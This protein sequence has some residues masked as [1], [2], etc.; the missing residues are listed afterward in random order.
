MY[1]I[2]ALTGTGEWA[3]YGSNIFFGCKNNCKY[4]YA[5][6]SAL[7]FKKISNS[8]E[9]EQMTLNKN[10]ANAI[11]RKLDRPFMFPT[12]H[13]ILSEHIGVVTDYLTR[14]LSVGNKVLIVTKP[15]L[16]CVKVLC[17]ELES[18]KSQ[19]LFRFTIG[20]LDERIST[21]WEP[22][23][24]LPS[25]RTQSLRYTFEKGFATSISAEP[26]L[27]SVEKARDMFYCLESL[28]TDT[29][30]FGKMNKISKRV[31]VSPQDM[32]Y[33]ELIKAQQTD[34]NIRKLYYMLKLEP[35]VMWKDSI[36]AVL[37]I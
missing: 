33:V 26:M 19:I 2:Q 24:T 30:W 15:H 34:D 31:H 17:R 5:R 11:P 6:A 14:W 1:K 35:K 18:F 20:T 12:S 8:T 16:E 29:I 25:E 36:K 32:K 21:F 28:I 23:A 13:D 22:G 10:E 4:C 9:W 37:G 3:G 7:R 27:C